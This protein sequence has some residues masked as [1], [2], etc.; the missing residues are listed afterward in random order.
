MSAQT[1]RRL[2]THICLGALF[3]L[4]C[5]PDVGATGEGGVTRVWE[6]AKGR[7]NNEGREQLGGETRGQE[8]TGNRM[9]Q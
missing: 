8:E 3:S 1:G 2:A 4:A 7:R 5:T 6:N 9:G